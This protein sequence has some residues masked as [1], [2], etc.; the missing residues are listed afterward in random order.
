MPKR[1]R[2]RLA[3]TD[4]WVQLRLLCT[5]PEQEAYELIR[6]VVLFGHSSAER[7]RQTGTSRR[8]LDRK[9]AAFAQLGMAGL[10]PEPPGDGRQRLPDD[11]RQAIVDLKAEY[12]ALNLREIATICYVRFG[13][14]PSHHTV[15]RVMT[16]EPIPPKT[17]R[18]FP[19]YHEIADPIQ[20]RLAIIHLQAEGWNIQSVAAYLQTSRPPV[21]ATLKRWVAEE[22]ADLAD[23]AHTRKKV[24]L[25][26][27]LKA[28]AEVRRLQA[29][30]ELGEFRIHAALKQQL[31]IDLSPPTCGR[32]LA[33][34]RS[35]YGLDRPPRQ[36]HER[37]AMP[38]EATHRHQFWTVDI[39][40][41]DMHRLG[42]G[43]IYVISILENYSRAI[44]A[45]ALSRTQDLAAFL[46]VFYAAIRAFG[47]PEALVSDGG[48]VFKANDALRIYAA[49]GIQKEQI[50][51]RQ[52]WQSYIET[53]FNVQRRMADW[54][55][56]KAITWEELVASHDRWVSDYSA[57]EH[58]AH[59]KRDDHRRSPQEVLE[60]VTGKSWPLEELQQIFRV[61]RGERRVIA[62]GYVRFRPWAIYG[63]RGLARQ[64][65]AVW[66]AVDAE[67]L[68]IARA[69]ELLAQYTVAQEATRKHLK[70]VTPLHLFQ[71]RFRSPQ[72]MLWD[73]SAV[74][75]RLALP[76]PISTARRRHPLIEVR[77]LPLFPNLTV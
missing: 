45:S 40:Y 71:T 68:T 43:M 16:E 64:R 42:G 60:W 29:N 51:K 11:V 47:S 38:F 61:A 58:W 62:A 63:E 9:A 14:R 3:T 36:P 67:T 77:Q 44:L 56:A 30:P 49:L 32:I 66:L 52:A 26:T 65:L 72:L 50:E 25:K 28:M 34:N 24:A 19:P 6:P 21:Y 53:H 27:D 7:A 59:R 54:H 13:Q 35:L 8:S 46:I 55:F 5:W 48:A 70:S 39:R 10:T 12:A 37:K 20:P 76:R 74:D 18:R 75:W 2:V 73:P 22:F 41:L 69:E 23:H 4:D 33:L 15:Q 31:D 1:K 17:T 57:Q